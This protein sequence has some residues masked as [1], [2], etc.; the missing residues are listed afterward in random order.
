M[1]PYDTGIDQRTEAK[2]GLAA[3]KGLAGIGISFSCRR[4]ELSGKRKGKY[5]RNNKIENSIP[6]SLSPAVSIV[7]VDR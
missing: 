1:R 5:V 2:V 3:S 6:R 4:S 7:S